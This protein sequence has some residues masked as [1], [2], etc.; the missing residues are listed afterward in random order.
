MTNVD[1]ILSHPTGATILDNAETQPW[2]LPSP[3]AVAPAGKQLTGLPGAPEPV[4]QAK[5]GEQVDALKVR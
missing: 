2:T 5:V 4:D 1:G 3:A